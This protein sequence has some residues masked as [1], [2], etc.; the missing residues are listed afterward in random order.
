MSGA[1][2]VRGMIGSVFVRDDGAAVLTF[3]DF[4]PDGTGQGFFT[5]APPGYISSATGRGDSGQR[6]AVPG[7]VPALTGYVVAHTAKT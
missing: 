1:L 3:A 2:S 5:L 4:N 7:D 6:G